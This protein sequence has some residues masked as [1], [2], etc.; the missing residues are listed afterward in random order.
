MKHMATTRITRKAGHTV[1]QPYCANIH[2]SCHYDVA[3]H[4]AVTNVLYSGKKY[5]RKERTKHATH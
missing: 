2:C 5:P 3:Y 1:K 4:S